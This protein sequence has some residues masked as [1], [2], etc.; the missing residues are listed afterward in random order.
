MEKKLALKKYSSSLN[1]KDNL[2]RVAA[3][4]V[5]VDVDDGENNNEDEKLKSSKII[6]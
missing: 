6:F 4:A 2:E 1:D 5:D 3:A